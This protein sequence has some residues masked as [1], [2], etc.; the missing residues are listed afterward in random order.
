M[1]KVYVEEVWDI[2]FPGKLTG[3]RSTAAA[4]KAWSSLRSMCPFI[5]E[6][7]G[8]GEEEGEEQEKERGMFATCPSLT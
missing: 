5:S 6:E 7:E 4:C 3:I 2:H 1:V 8:R